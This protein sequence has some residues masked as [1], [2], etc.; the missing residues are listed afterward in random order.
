MPHARFPRFRISNMSAG[1]DLIEQ[2]LERVFYC[3]F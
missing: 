1:H 2:I 3:A